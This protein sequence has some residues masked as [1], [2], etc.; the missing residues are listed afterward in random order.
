[1][2]P[3]RLSG[4]ASDV[5]RSDLIFLP[6]DGSL[7]PFDGGFVMLTPSNPTYWW[8]NTLCFDRPPRDDD[9]EPWN[10]AFERYVHAVQPESSHRTF[11]WDGAERGQIDRF[12]ADGFAYFETIEVHADRGDVVRAPKPDADV[13]IVRLAGSDWDALRALQVET[14]DP[15]HSAAGYDT[16]IARRIVGWRALE[17]RG[18]GCWFGVR[19]ETND[20]AGTIV[21][22]LGVFAEARRGHDGRRIGRFQHVTTHPSMRRRG[23]A[24]LL[25]EHASRFAFDRLDVD[26]LLIVADA[27]DVARRVYEGCGYRVRSIQHG[28]ER[29]S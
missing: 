12:V 18:Q 2:G 28:L 6:E 10:R 14:R 1:V 23:L 16:F 21:A 7:T 13:D 9:F 8:G 15:P 25:V 24:S 27:N 17:A 29:A 20:A 3:A 4:G 26:T 11:G 5:L 19:G 22:A